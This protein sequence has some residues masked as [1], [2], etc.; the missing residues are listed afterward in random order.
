MLWNY[1]VLYFQFIILYTFTLIEIQNLNFFKLFVLRLWF[2]ED[3]MA[4]WF[5]QF[6][7]DSWCQLISSLFITFCIID[8]FNIDQILMAELALFVLS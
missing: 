2:L 3:C 8:F 5:S 4:F 1:D 6:W 7:F